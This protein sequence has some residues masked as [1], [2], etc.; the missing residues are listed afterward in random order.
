MTKSQ[1][2]SR[3]RLPSASEEPQKF[4]RPY[5]PPRER[6]SFHLSISL[7]GV[8]T[9]FFLFFSLISLLSLVQASFIAQPQAVANE[10]QGAKE[11]ITDA[12]RASKA[13]EAQIREV[14]FQELPAVLNNLPVERS[15]PVRG[16]ITT[17]F[18]SYHPAI[19]IATSQGTPIHSFASG[20]VVTARTGGSFGRY[21]VIRH[22][23]GY[24]TAYAHLNTILVSEGQQVD[25]STVIG[26][27]G[28]T[29]R[30]TGPHLHFQLTKDGRAVNP[31][32]TLP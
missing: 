22:N 2:W 18:S 1:N 20:I 21:V 10:V 29:G 9:S 17:N 19:D 16:R 31:L 8:V 25:P 7:V 24:E 28:S 3:I 32:R 30:S 5:I 6:R 4:M 15:W 27:V 14:R 13:S 11:Q 26:T 23:D 12:V